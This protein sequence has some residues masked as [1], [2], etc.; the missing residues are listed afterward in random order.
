MYSK[1]LKRL[2][3]Y[4]ALA[5]NAVAICLRFRSLNRM[6]SNTTRVHSHRDTI[7]VIRLNRQCRRMWHTNVRL[8][9]QYNR[10]ALVLVRKIHYRRI[11]SEAYRYLTV[12]FIIQQPYSCSARS[13]LQYAQLCFRK[14]FNKAGIAYRQEVLNANR[15]I[16]VSQIPRSV[17]TWLEEYNTE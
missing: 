2:V 7:D 4:L 13:C 1:A 15:F 10:D 8:V 9:N 17:N 5:L 11:H 6:T 12:L 3:P 14:L 16:N